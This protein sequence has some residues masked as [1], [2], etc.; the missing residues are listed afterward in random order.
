MVIVAHLI[1]HVNIDLF[2]MPEVTW[3][4]KK[5]DTMAVCVDRLSG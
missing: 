2:A 1:D 3:E 4:G 5:Y